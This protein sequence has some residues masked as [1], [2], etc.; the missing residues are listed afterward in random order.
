[1]YLDAMRTLTLG[2]AINIIT[3]AFPVAASALIPEPSLATLKPL[4]GG[5]GNTPPPEI[6]WTPN[7]SPECASINMGELQCCQG[8]LAGDLPLIQFLAAVFGYKLDPNDVNGVLCSNNLENCPGI[9]ACCQVTALD[10]A[11]EKGV[12]ASRES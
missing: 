2:F 8:S 12:N 5:L 10:Y 7:P 9:K 11:S 3:T 1:M 6:I 4:L